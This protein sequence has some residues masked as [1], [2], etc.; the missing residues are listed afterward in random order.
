MRGRSLF[1]LAFVGVL[2]AFN[3]Q[4]AG[5]CRVQLRTS[6]AL[7]RAGPLLLAP[8]AVNGT[9]VDFVLDTGAER[10]VI[11]L[12]AAAQLHLAR[13][14]WVSTDIQGAGGRDRRRLGRPN[15][16]SL[17]GMALRRHSVA[18]DNSVVVGAIPDSVDGHPVAGL[19]G[20]DFLSPFDLDLDAPGGKLSLYE[21]SGCG[22]RFLPWSG[23]YAAI[24]AGRPV[25][26]MLTLPLRVGGAV[27]QAELD[28]GA[29]RTAI[30]LPGM[31]QLGLP[32]G[33]G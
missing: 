7:Q 4:A 11:G 32:A 6:V 5:P 9:L 13:D 31:L 8:V 18:A 2:A 33:G 27:L 10:S 26:N 16:L 22:G 23:R 28:S 15:S 29:A 14:E 24:P 20:Q 1:R 12:Q 25:R 19:L 17:G 30:T 21:V 3:A